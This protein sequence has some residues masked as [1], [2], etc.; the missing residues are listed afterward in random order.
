MVL[1]SAIEGVLR[2][3]DKNNVMG[4]YFPTEFIVVTSH[5]GYDKAEQE[6]TT[7]VNIIFDGNDVPLHR[8]MGLVEWARNWMRTYDEAE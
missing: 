2:A 6:G 8:A 7:M 1:R 5:T 3:N 4:E